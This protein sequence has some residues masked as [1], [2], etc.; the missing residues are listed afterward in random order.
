MSDDHDRGDEL[1]TSERDGLRRLY[2]D[3]VPGTGLE[4]RTVAELRARGRLGL[5]VGGHQRRALR[6]AALRFAAAVALFAAE[7]LVG[8]S[9]SRGPFPAQPNESPGRR[10]TVQSD[11]LTGPESGPKVRRVVWL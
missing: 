11:T 5:P 4:D 10:A 3:D 9:G 6:R 1:S 8:R 2:A 7:V